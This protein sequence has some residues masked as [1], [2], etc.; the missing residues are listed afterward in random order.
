MDLLD[1]ECSSRADPTTTSVLLYILF[2]GFKDDIDRQCTTQEQLCLAQKESGSVV[3]KK[4]PFK[5]IHSSMY[6]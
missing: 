4:M 3:V 1:A 2:T 6:L 5:M